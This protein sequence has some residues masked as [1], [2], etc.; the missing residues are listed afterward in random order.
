LFAIAGKIARRNRERNHVNRHR[1]K[2]AALALGALALAP[3]ACGPS[4]PA[5]RVFVRRC[6]ACHGQ[7]GR[8]RTR[9]AEGRPF[10][11]LTD[12]RWKHGGDRASIRKLVVEGDPASPMPPFQDRL[13][14]REIDLS[15]DY[16]VKLAA[17]G[18]APPTTP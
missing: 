17:G 5:E 13:S 11:D 4:D 15:V 6:A 16:V 10:A 3:A 12:G 2:V 7:D 14:A 9:F 18:A 8:G 1:L